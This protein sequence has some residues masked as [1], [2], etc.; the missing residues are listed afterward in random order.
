MGCITIMGIQPGDAKYMDDLAGFKKS[1][2]G[3]S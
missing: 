3:E 1:E 2:H